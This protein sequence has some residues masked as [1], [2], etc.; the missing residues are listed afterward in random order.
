[1]NKIILK[2]DNVIISKLHYGAL[3]PES[4]MEIP[5][6]NALYFLVYGNDL[7]KKW[8]PYRCYGFSGIK[9]NDIMV[10]KHPLRHNITYIKRCVCLPGD[11]LQIKES[12][13]FIN[14]KSFN[15][16]S[17]IKG[18][19]IP[20]YNDLTK[21]L[22][23]DSGL[24]PGNNEFN[25]SINNFGPIVI[26]KAGMKIRLTKDNILRYGTI[27]EKYENLVTK[28]DSVLYDSN[29]GESMEYIF[30]KNYH[31]MLGDNRQHSIDSR[32]W[33][34]VPEENIIGKAVTVCWSVEPGYTGLKSIRWKRIGKSL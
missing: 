27:L 11:T 8:N 30:K 25:W 5:V 13:V 29:D 33:G 21:R 22:N 19:C 18:V 26:P 23:I 9:R 3:T 16:A 17:A 4:P 15:E 10:F 24:Y 7:A 1:M 31:F 2:G 20:K 12:S 14:S 28:G 32:Y 34:F 6:V